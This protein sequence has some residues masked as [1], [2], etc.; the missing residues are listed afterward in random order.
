MPNSDAVEAA[1][2]IQRVEA[3]SRSNAEESAA[4][5]ELNAGAL[6]TIETDD[7]PAPEPARRTQPAA[8]DDRP[9]PQPRRPVLSPNDQRRADIINH[10]RR[11]RNEESE[12]ADRDDDEVRRMANTGL[13]PEL[14]E[15]FVDDEDDGSGEQPQPAERVAAR[16]PVDTAAAPE[17]RKHKLIVR[18]Q[19]VYLTDAELREHAQ[20]S[21]AH[22]DY[23]S[24]ARNVLDRAKEAESRLNAALSTVQG[25]RSTPSGTH[26]ATDED[27]QTGDQ[28][29]DAAPQAD[30][31]GSLVDALQMGDRESAIATVRDFMT[32]QLPAV[33]QVE[34]QRGR[35]VEEYNDSMK[36]LGEF[37]ERHQDI[38]Q[39]R[40]ANAA[41]QATLVDLQR[42]DL[43]KLGRNEPQLADDNYVAVE[44]LKARA[45]RMNVRSPQQMLD[46]SL[47]D[48]NKWHG[49]TNP[50]NPEPVPTGQQHQR[51]QAQ[52]QPDDR[53]PQPQPAKRVEVSLNRETRRAAIPQQPERTVAPRANPAA[54]VQPKPKDR[55]DVVRAMQ[56]RQAKLRGQVPVT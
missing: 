41:F 33:S 8:D 32:K 45:A 36:V 3:R 9:S 43:K 23:L 11:G 16:P 39:D 31:Y 25:P 50:P 49:R 14:Q 40:R 51:S 29:G 6:D 7:G 12:Q 46:A 42:E 35:L 4:D 47:E 17:E 21:V 54:P 20:K 52:Q 38:A 34:V 2:E 53:Q 27:A 28:P 13:P 26:A 15:T 10:F 5:R 48:F 1:R 24:E 55:S 56:E 19:E 18:G 44:H 22:D 37:A 30:P